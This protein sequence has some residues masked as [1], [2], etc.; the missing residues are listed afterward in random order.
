MI[1]ALICCIF[2]LL[3]STGFSLGAEP[4]KKIYLT[5]SSVAD[6]IIANV[7]SQQLGFYKDEGIE[8]EI[9]LTRASVAI[10][11]LLGGAADYINHTSVTPAIMRGTPLKVLL[12]DSDKPTHYFVTSSKVSAMKDLIGKSIGIDD[13][14]GN[15]GLLARELLVRQGLSPNQVNLRVIGPP[16]FRLQA[17]LGGVVD[18][19][20]LNYSLARYAQTKGF[21]TLVY[22]GDLISELGPSL[23]TTQAKLKNAPEEVYGMVKATLKGYLIMY[24]NPEEGLKFFMQVQS[25]NDVASARDAWQARLKRTSEASRAGMASDE[26]M[27]DTLQQV[28]RQLE[29]G[30]APLQAKELRSDTVYD[31]TIA[32]RALAELK[33]ENWD[34]KKYRYVKK[35]ML[36]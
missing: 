18:A 15:A 25:L 31:F 6:K 16:P 27:A 9:V 2:F 20:L 14:A 11:G 29:I 13:F 5:T 7:I 4:P 30:G 17:L 10:Q 35:G 33:A 32:R 1:Q 24:E 28:K 26:A 23:A 3:L 36:R 8:L 12:I 19:T 22:T 21:R 34:P